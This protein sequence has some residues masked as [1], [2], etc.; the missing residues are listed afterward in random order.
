[1]V[2]VLSIVL[3]FLVMIFCVVFP[4]GV[5]VFIKIK[6]K[7]GIVP[8]FLG[9]GTFLLFALILERI[10]H[11]IFINV[12]PTGTIISN[13]I[14]LYG[15]YG[16]TCAALFEET[17][18]LIVMKFLMKRWYKND[19]NALAFGIGHGGFEAMSIISL[20]MANNIV[21]AIMINCGMTDLL[22]KDVPADMLSIAN[23]Q[24]QTLIDTPSINYILGGAERVIA[25]CFH[26]CASVL[27]WLAVTRARKLWVYFI[28]F[29]AHFA[30]DF[31]AVILS[32]YI[33]NVVLVE[34][35][36]ALFVVVVLVV[37]MLIY[38]KLKDTE[39]VGTT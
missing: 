6:Y 15:L 34:V 8:F 28:A 35:V 7:S 4:I 22:L 33:T 25:I 31:L 9:C 11:L 29:A 26:I 10:V 12:L 19:A 14:F 13:N 21:L 20:T 5:F 17:G 16:A 18:R 32:N 37:T 2:S 27:V 36:L 39:L 3:M 23:A 30:F 24:L 38:K 1:M